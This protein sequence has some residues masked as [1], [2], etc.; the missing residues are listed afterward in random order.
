MQPLKKILVAI[1]DLDARSMPA[2]RKAAQLA[3]ASAATLEL[4]HSLSDTI[5]VEALDARRVSLKDFET[6]R[7]AQTLNR[8]EVIGAAPISAG[9]CCRK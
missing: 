6:Q 2:V 5:L 7:L 8:L 9:Q 3:K 1:K 4:F